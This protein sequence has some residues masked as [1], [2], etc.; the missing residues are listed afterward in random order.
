MRK[1]S[2]K[3]TNGAGFTIVE[4]L[5]VMAVIVILIGLLV[6][7]LNLVRDYA[8]EIQQRAQFHSM[9]IAIEMFKTEFGKYPPSIDNINVTFDTNLGADPDGYS[10]SLK[11]SEA[12][13][14]WDLLGFHPNSDFRSDGQNVRDDGLGSTEPYDVY[15]PDAPDG[16]NVNG[17]FAET[18]QENVQARKGPLVELEGAN[19]FQLKDIYTDFGSF[20][21]DS[22]VLCDVYAKKRGSN[23]KI[24]MPILYYTART[25]YTQQKS[26]DADGIDNDIY[27]YLDNVDLLELGTPEDE[28]A[29]PLAD[30]ELGA[31]DPAPAASSGLADADDYLD[32][33]NMIRNEQVTTINRPYRAESYILISAG[34]DGLYGSADDIYNFAKE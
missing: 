30:G 20:N 28:T 13:V 25:R 2:K 21:G 14:G 9:D 19:A 12:L 31:A 4:L 33:E 16:G 10:G 26:D 7:A 3:L 11:L 34:K 22:F 17:Q 24:G 8:K 5:T 32:F 27:N 15:H 18:A 6:P 1:E 23:K 29:H